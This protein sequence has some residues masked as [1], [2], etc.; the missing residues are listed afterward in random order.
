MQRSTLASVHGERLVG[1]ALRGNKSERHVHVVL[2]AS[3]LF[4]KILS[5]ESRCIPCKQQRAAISIVII[6]YF[7]ISSYSMFYRFY[8]ALDNSWLMFTLGCRSFLG[9]KSM[10]LLR[11]QLFLVRLL[12]L[13]A[14]KQPAFQTSCRHHQALSR[15]SPC[16]HEHCNTGSQMW[17]ESARAS[18]F[19]N[20]L[21]FLASKLP[22]QAWCFPVQ[23]SCWN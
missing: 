6:V 17:T 15:W 8:S 9:Q 4:A 2:S 13:L 18:G 19:S 1:H 3:V 23:N 10:V 21:S 20:S 11:A 5:C 16:D 12:V 14:D 22:W 7:N